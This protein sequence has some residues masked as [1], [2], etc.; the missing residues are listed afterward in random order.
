MVRLLKL[1][2]LALL[3]VLVGAVGGV[4]VYDAWFSQ[5][6]EAHIVPGAGVPN[7]IQADVEGLL[8]PYILD[9]PDRVRADIYDLCLTTGTGHFSFKNNLKAHYIGDD[10]WVV[11]AGDSCTFTVS[12]RTGKVTGP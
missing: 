9:K 3:L 1:L 8:V 4:T 5:D 10:T 12:D 2:G 6:V 11:K 7:M